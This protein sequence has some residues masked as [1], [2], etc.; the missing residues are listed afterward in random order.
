MSV[1]LDP[2]NQQGGDGE[3]FQTDKGNGT[4]RLV[5]EKQPEEGTYKPSQHGGEKED[6]GQDKRLR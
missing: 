1:L 6:G 2:G 4:S 5:T 3:G